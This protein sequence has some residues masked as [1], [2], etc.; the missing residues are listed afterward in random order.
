MKPFTVLFLLFPFVAA[1]FSYGQAAK[2]TLIDPDNLN[3]RLLEYFIKIK[4]DSVRQAHGLNTL[5]SD[6]LLYLAAQDQVKYQ[7]KKED[8]THFQH[9]RK[10]K[11]LK[12]RLDFY[13]ASFT[14]AG[15][16]LAREFIL[17]PT[18]SS[19]EKNKKTVIIHT[20]EQ[21]AY[22][23]VNGWVHSPGHYANII[24]AAFKITGVA[25]SFD[26]ARKQLNGAQVFADVP[27]TYTPRAAPTFFPYENALQGKKTGKKVKS[28]QHK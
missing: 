7:L 24:T 9:S 17:V 3:T 11:T 10:K 1:P 20:Y 28:D 15:E 14:S 25:V 12:D 13:N 22:Q 8:L 21:A 27:P 2:D 18:Y 23:M 6:S 4:I 16:N 5:R 26:P 19:G